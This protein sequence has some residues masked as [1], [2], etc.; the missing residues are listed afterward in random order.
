MGSD[1]RKAQSLD[2]DGYQIDSQWG[3]LGIPGGP[4]TKNA[5]LWE[6]LISDLGLGSFL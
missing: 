1:D 4:T 6:T 2:S 3:L 5:V